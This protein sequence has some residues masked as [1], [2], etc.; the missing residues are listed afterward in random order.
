V[1]IPSPLAYLCIRYLSTYLS[2][3]LQALLICTLSLLEFL[4]DILQLHL[5]LLLF[6]L[7]SH[8]FLQLLID[9][10]EVI[11]LDLE[12][13]HLVVLDLSLQL[14]FLDLIL[15]FIDLTILILMEGHVFLQ[16]VVS[17]FEFT[18]ESVL[19]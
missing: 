8:R 12:R 5:C 18:A 7:F 3:S 19:S 14:Q 17:L 16:L 13:S 2:E 6:L 1:C 11:D 10:L 4:S 9:S 15:K